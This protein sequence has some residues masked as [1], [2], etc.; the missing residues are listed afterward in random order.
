MRTM[1]LPLL[2]KMVSKKKLT[3]L[4]MLLFSLSLIYSSSIDTI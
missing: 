3:T 4:T 2:L 1:L